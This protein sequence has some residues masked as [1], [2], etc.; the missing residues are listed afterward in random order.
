M[1]YFDIDEY[2]EFV[3]KSKT[4]N[5]YL[6]EDRFKKCEVIKINWLMFNDNNLIYYDNRTLQER[7]TEPN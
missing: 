3:N 4:I 7:F 1:I 6:S 5:E 2:L